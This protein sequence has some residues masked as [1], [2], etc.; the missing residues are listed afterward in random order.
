MPVMTDFNMN[1]SLE[2]NFLLQL[3]P[4]DYIAKNTCQNGILSQD[5]GWGEL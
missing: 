3:S 5:C 2:I 1:V 4:K